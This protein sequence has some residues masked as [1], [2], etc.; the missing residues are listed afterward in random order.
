MD[1]IQDFEQAPQV[2]IAVTEQEKLLPQS[3]V[4]KLVAREKENAA[5]RARQQAEEEFQARLAQMGLAQTQHNA[6]TSREVDAEAVY[7][8][9]Q[10][11]FNQEMERRRQ[12]EESKRLEAEMSQVAERYISKVNAARES[13]ED[14]DDVV[15]EF[16]PTA[17]P[18]LT[19]LVSGVENAGDVVY[20]LAKNPSKLVMLDRLAEKNPKQAQNELLKLSRSIL[21]NRQAINEASGQNVSAPLDRLNPS[22]VSGSNGKMNIRDLRNQPWLKG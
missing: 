4:N 18:Q 15:G 11:K 14:F 12:E 8:Q 22:R 9:V 19:Y 21:E 13:Y 1:E 5:A 3:Q 17:F 20:E 2:E 7:R 16:D 10:E 6:A